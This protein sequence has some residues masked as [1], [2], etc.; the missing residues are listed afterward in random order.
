MVLVFQKKPCPKYFTI[1][2][3]QELESTEQPITYESKNIFIQVQ[4]TPL[5]RMNHVRLI[6]KHKD[7][8]CIIPVDSSTLKIRK[9]FIQSLQHLKEFEIFKIVTNLVMKENEEHKLLSQRFMSNPSYDIKE[10]EFTKLIKF[11]SFKHKTMNQRNH[12]MKSTSNVNLSEDESDCSLDFSSFKDEEKEIFT[13][14]TAIVVSEVISLRKKR[15]YNFQP[16]DSE[17]SED[18][19]PKKNRRRANYAPRK[20]CGTRP[21]RK[22]SGT[23]RTNYAP[24]KSCGMRPP[25]KFQSS[26]EDETEDQSD[27]MELVEEH[28]SMDIFMDE[29]ES[30]EIGEGYEQVSIWVEGKEVKF[31]VNTIELSD[32]SFHSWGGVINL[33][34]NSNP[35]NVNYNKQVLEIIFRIINKQSLCLRKSLESQDIFQLLKFMELNLITQTNGEFEREI[36]IKSI[37]EMSEN[38][39]NLLKERFQFDKLKNGK[40]MLLKLTKIYEKKKQ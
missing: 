8:S 27:H 35:F 19:P 23:Y 36:L 26:G 5:E 37:S 6:L 40:S 17:S 7:K 33:R 28:P 29:T 20:S 9:D 15:I 11:D 18:V 34:S 14:P 4:R 22:S 2:E 21:P 38:D 10:E 3:G 31:I 16:D 13:E 1:F 30:L 24:R 12:E 25:R 39:F 32:Y